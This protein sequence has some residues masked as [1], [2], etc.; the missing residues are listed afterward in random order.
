MR[1]LCVKLSFHKLRVA[2]MKISLHYLWSFTTFYTGQYAC[3]CEAV[4]FVIAESNCCFIAAAALCVRCHTKRKGDCI[5]GSTFFLGLLLYNNLLHNNYF[6]LP[7]GTAHAL[8]GCFAV[9]KTFFFTLEK[10]SLVTSIT[11]LWPIRSQGDCLA[12]RAAAPTMNL[13]SVSKR[14]AAASLNRMGIPCSLQI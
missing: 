14:P 13:Y 11:E 4:C 1:N 9:T 10:L 5:S 2:K 3:T 8:L 6:F 12:P 7:Q